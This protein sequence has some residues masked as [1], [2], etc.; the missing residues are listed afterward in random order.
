MQDT[1]LYMEASIAVYTSGLRLI[2]VYT[3]ARPYYE[4][5]FEDH[6]HRFTSHISRKVN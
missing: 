4:T 1:M 5:N 2:L 6:T 3:N